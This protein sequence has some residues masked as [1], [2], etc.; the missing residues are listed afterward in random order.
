MSCGKE[1]LAST[2]EPASG[3]SHPLKSSSPRF[4]SVVHSPLLLFGLY[5]F[6]MD[7]GFGKHILEKT[8]AY[9]Y[10]YTIARKEN[11]TLQ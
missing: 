6:Y 7:G 3:R 11:Q 8:V 5:A 2:S 9:L 4:L 1:C 10:S